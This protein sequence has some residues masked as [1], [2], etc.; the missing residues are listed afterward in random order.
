MNSSHSLL[1][2]L[3]LSPEPVTIARTSGVIR[4]ASRNGALC[5]LRLRTS[6]PLPCG[7]DEIPL[8]TW[9]KVQRFRRCNADRQAVLQ[10]NCRLY[11]PRGEISRYPSPPSA[12]GIILTHRSRDD[13]Q[14][15][16]MNRLPPDQAQSQPLPPNLPQRTERTW[17]RREL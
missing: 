17:I 5:R 6:Q 14:T 16:S 2:L 1:D 12:V 15:K 4:E 13:P 10:Q 7:T 8:L 11:E 9:Q 3:L